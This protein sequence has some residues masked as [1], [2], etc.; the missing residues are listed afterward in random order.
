MGRCGAGA[1]LFGSLVGGVLGNVADL[2]F[3]SE[4][5]RSLGA[6]GVVMAA[7]GILVLPGTRQTLGGAVS[8]W[9]IRAVCGAS[10]LFVMIGLDPTSDV[11]AHAGG[12]AGGLLVGYVLSHFPA[13]RVRSVRVSALLLVVTLTIWLG[14]WAWALMAKAH[15]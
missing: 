9:A 2:V 15:G 10:L 13:A 4:A 6:S 14:A 11:V 12:F 7:L 5:H 1:A 8:H 3:H